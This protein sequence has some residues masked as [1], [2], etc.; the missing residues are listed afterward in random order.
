VSSFYRLQSIGRIYVLAKSR[1]ASV[2]CGSILNFLW[3][4]A[5]TD[6]GPSTEIFLDTLI[7]LHAL[8]MEVSILPHSI[9]LLRNIRCSTEHGFGVVQLKVRARCVMTDC[10]HK[11]CL[12]D[13][14]TVARFRG[15]S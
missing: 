15:K 1:F 14:S 5:A 7:S 6:L 9:I 2:L 3:A 13:V 4:V 8:D 12:R 11:M 10:G